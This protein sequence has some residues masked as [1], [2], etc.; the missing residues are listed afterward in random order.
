MGMKPEVDG[1]RRGRERVGWRA[2]DGHRY[3]RSAGPL[4]IVHDGGRV[5][6]APKERTDG[7]QWWSLSCTHQYGHAVALMMR[8]LACC[9][10]PPSS[11]SLIRKALPRWVV[12]AGGSLAQMLLASRK[13]EQIHLVTSDQ[14]TDAATAA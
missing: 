4:M 1:R 13:Q 3:R 14:S 7:Q 12:L 10:L 2:V 5:D 8:A 9:D 11:K 6:D